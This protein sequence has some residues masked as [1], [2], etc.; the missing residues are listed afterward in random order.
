MKSEQNFNQAYNLVCLFATASFFLRMDLSFILRFFFWFFS[1]NHFAFNF[2]CHFNARVLHL[3]R[4]DLFEL[5][6]KKT[7]IAWIHMAKN[8]ISFD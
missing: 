2:L 5:E 8:T 1:T 6:W 7:F 3:V 4:F